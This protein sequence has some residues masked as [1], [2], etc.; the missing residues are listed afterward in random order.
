MSTPSTPHSKVTYTV[1]ANGRVNIIFDGMRGHGELMSMALGIAAHYSFLQAR[2]IAVLEN[3]A[4]F[5]IVK[6]A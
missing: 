2:P 1:K 3:G 6:V 5:R 4:P